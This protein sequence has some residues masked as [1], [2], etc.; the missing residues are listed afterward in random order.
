MQVSLVGRKS[1]L[2]FIVFC[3]TMLSLYINLPYDAMGHNTHESSVVA[4]IFDW[5]LGRPEA[6]WSFQRYVFATR[7]KELDASGIFR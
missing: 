3:T 7:I 6:G 2:G 1:T 5:I 4:G